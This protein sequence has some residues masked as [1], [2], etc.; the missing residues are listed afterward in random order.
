[1][2]LL[3]LDTATET[4]ALGVAHESRSL[5]MN[6]PG[7]AQASVRLIPDLLAL[8]SAARLQIVEV[9]AIAVGCGPGAFTGLRSAV[10]VAQGLALGADKP[11]LPIDSL[12]IVAE[13]AR[14]QAQRARSSEDEPMV[15]P[16]PFECWV[17]MD[18][19]MDEIYAGA[20]QHD[21]ECWRITQAPALVD[22]D[23]LHAHWAAQPPR[24]VAGTAL[25]AFQGRLV[26]GAARRW[27]R[28]EDRAVALLHLARAAW[29]SGAH[30]QP[31]EL[32]PV[33]LRDK[34]AMTTAER[35]AVRAATLALANANAA[36]NVDS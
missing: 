30:C 15:P 18:A 12:M 9:D 32:A 19:R 23:H 22:P 4:M 1:M 33:Y 17:L 16:T 35:E 27:P 8:L 6:E 7:G 34:V 29:Q 28:Q 14:R 10:S 2:K 21:G 20:Y 26:T 5:S 25:E 31:D 11:V 24:H 36:G 3:A 13:D